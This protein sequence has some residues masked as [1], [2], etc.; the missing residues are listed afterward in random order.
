VVSDARIVRL[1]IERE[2][3]GG[4]G[5]PRREVPVPPAISEPSRLDARHTL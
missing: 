5:G 1:D 3:T 4:Y 2:I